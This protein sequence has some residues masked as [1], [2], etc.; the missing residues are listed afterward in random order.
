MN[1]R[2]G[3]HHLFGQPA[4][5]HI[6]RVEQVEDEAA[7]VERIVEVEPLALVGQQPQ[8]VQ[9]HHHQRAQHEEQPGAA[10]FVVAAD[11]ALIVEGGI[12]VGQAAVV[13]DFPVELLRAI[14]LGI[15]HK[16]I[17]DGRVIGPVGL[18]VKRQLAAAALVAVASRHR[19]VE[20]DQRHIHRESDAVAPPPWQAARP[21]LQLQP[22]VERHRPVVAVA[23]TVGR[24]EAV[25]VLAGQHFLRP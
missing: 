1:R 23:E 2:P 17:G 12:L 15:P 4:H 6:G 13:G 7:E 24:H 22:A 9:Q 25:V 14:V 11:D 18:L 21:P 10:F 20:V 5:Q 8:V 16:H 3:R 19:L